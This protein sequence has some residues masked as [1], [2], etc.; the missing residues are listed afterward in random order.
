MG[1]YTSTP[2]FSEI[3]F[4]TFDR[5]QSPWIMEFS[6]SPGS[7][8]TSLSMPPFMHDRYLIHNILVEYFSHFLETLLPVKSLQCTS[9]LMRSLTEK[10]IENM[11]KT[12]KR[13][14][15]QVGYF[16]TGQMDPNSLRIVQNADQLQ[17]LNILAYAFGDIPD[18]LNTSTSLLAANI[19]AYAGPIEFLVRLGST[20]NLEVLR[21]QRESWTAI[22]HSAE[23]L[24]SVSRY[25]IRTLDLSRCWFKIS[26]AESISKVWPFVATLVIP[27]YIG[28]VQTQRR[29]FRDKRFIFS[30][31]IN[32]IVLF[33]KL[34]SLV[35]MGD[36]FGYRIPPISIPRKF[37][38]MQHSQSLH[39]IIISGIN[40]YHWESSKGWVCGKKTK[41][42]LPEY[43]KEEVQEVDDMFRRCLVPYSADIGERLKETWRSRSIGRL[44]GRVYT[45]L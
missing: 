5:I 11:K 44:F 24:D 6:V 4:Y 28:E 22:S 7:I 29:M 2:H 37:R 10:T 20:P 42:N 17:V 9:T 32:I 27:R 14:S 33:V 41:K 21:L 35:I 43:T 18:N 25:Q 12:L 30:K 31:L 26:D 23:N 1:F 8:P 3:E 16:E 40:T 39:T 19:T 45:E 34:E 36:A 13:F 15:I 38:E